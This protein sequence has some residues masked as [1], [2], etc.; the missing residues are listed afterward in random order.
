MG[1]ADEHQL[2][3]G[4]GEV[5]FCIG[6]GLNVV[7]G[8]W[9]G[10]IAVRGDC[11]FK[12]ARVGQGAQPGQIR[13]VKRIAMATDGLAGEVNEIIRPLSAGDGIIVVA[14]ERRGG[15]APG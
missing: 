4:G 6:L 13:C 1:V 3:I 11:A 15:G 2:G 5:G 7:K 9:L 12:F 10:E 8:A 14:G